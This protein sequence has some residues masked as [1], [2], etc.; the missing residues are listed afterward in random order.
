MAAKPVT[1]TTLVD[2]ALDIGRTLCV[3]AQPADAGCT[4]TSSVAQGADGDELVLGFGDVGA[5]LYDGCAGVALALAACAQASSEDMLVDQALAAITHALS[6]AEG[7]LEG[8]RL[9][10]FDG[11]TGVA[12]AATEVGR[13]LGDHSTRERGDALAKRIW[14]TF[15]ADATLP[16]EIDLIGG[17][18]GT[19]LG[20]SAC[21]RT[22]PTDGMDLRGAAAV[23]AATVQP[24]TWGAAWP[25]AAAAPGGPPLLGMGH[26][27]A[28]IALA[29]ME[30]GDERA[31][32]ACAAALEYERSWFD[33]GY[34][35]WPDLRSFSADDSPAPGMAAWCHGAIG[36]GLSR[37]RLSAFLPDPQLPVEATAALQAA[38]N[39]TVQAGTALHRGVTRDCSSCHG[40]A[41]AAELM[42]IGAQAFGV[43]GHR[44]AAQRVA[45]LILE[46][47]AAK[48]EWP[49]GLPGAGEVPAL[50]T[51][52]A[53]LALT[54]LRVEGATDIPTPLLP[55][56][57]GW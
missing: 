25:T 37:L 18:A 40:L 4:W 31:Q 9:G 39:L 12:W 10:L 49:C 43:D 11:A 5:S 15:N 17:V 34:P 21:A 1:A 48:G 14:E 27:A 20:L 45:G 50:M 22:S 19:L 35:A 44:R 41:G 13:A 57:S 16:A 33:P 55:G 28:G 30:T 32:T 51:G 26:G 29:L 38:R 56:P 8:D 7:M 23:L 3:T 42:L 24:Q 36:I 53:G 52:T 6:D 46:Q 47:R 54:L 2:A